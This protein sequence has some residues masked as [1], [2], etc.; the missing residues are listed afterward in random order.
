M[1]PYGPDSHSSP[2]SG[3][4]GSRPFEVDATSAHSSA[5]AATAAR[6]RPS[7][8]RR[9][10]RV[11]RAQTWVPVRSSSI[12]ASSRSRSSSAGPVPAGAGEGDGVD[13][14]ERSP[15]VGVSSLGRDPVSRPGCGHPDEAAPRGAPS[16]SSISARRSVYLVNTSTLSTTSTAGMTLKLTTM[17]SIAASGWV[18]VCPAVRST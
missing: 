1:A 13:A 5:T 6:T 10:P 9:W 17:P 15:R 16:V 7:S 8:R 12:A 18:T 14:T 11:S 4:P 3:C 2:R